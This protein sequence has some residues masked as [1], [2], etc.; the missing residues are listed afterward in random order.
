MGWRPF[1][2]RHC[3]ALFYWANMVTPVLKTRTGESMAP[4][5]ARIKDDFTGHAARGCKH[6][7]HGNRLLREMCYFLRRTSVNPPRASKLS[8]AGSGMGVICW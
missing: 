1:S 8:V 3:I 2:G 7:N 4:K 5:E 6:R